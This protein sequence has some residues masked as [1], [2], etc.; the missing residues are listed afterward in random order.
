MLIKYSRSQESGVRSQE[1]EYLLFITI[2]IPYS[3][4]T[5]TCHLSPVPYIN[6]GKI[7]AGYQVQDVAKNKQND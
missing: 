6:F 7:Y 2:T 4:L 3:L 5:V 1:S